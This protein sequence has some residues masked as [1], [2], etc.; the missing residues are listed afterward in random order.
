[1]IRGKCISLRKVDMCIVFLF[2]IAHV[3]TGESDV[4]ELQQTII[5]ATD[6]CLNEAIAG[7]GIDSPMICAD[8]MDFKSAMIKCMQ[9]ILGELKLSS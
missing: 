6:T 4:Q 1:M 3:V 7:T 8:S 2:L 5:E 9:R